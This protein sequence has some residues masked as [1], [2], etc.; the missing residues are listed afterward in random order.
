[1]PSTVQTPPRMVVPF[2]GNPTPPPPLDPLQRSPKPR[3]MRP[4]WR[5]PSLPVAQTLLPP[6]PLSNPPHAPPVVPNVLPPVTPPRPTTVP[7][8]TAVQKVDAMFGGAPPSLPPLQEKPPTKGHFPT[9]ERKFTARPVVPEG[10][11]PTPLGVLGPP[12]AHSGWKALSDSLMGLTPNPVDHPLMGAIG[13]PTLRPVTPKSHR[14]VMS[15]NASLRQSRL[16]GNTPPRYGLED[17][18]THSFTLVHP[19]PPPVP[20][21]NARSSSQAFSNRASRVGSRARAQP[22]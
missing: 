14:R 18:L 9:R 16:F 15:R 3:V 1:M 11:Y 19:V 2:N 12:T 4:T 8:L 7:G 10:P 20:Q 5:A 17:D 13:Q 21:T 6:L 22:K